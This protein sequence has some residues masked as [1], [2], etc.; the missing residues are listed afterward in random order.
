M[1]KV[2]EALQKKYNL[3]LMNSDIAQD[4]YGP[5]KKWLRFYLNFCK[6]YSH[7]YADAK[8]LLLFLEKLQKKKQTPSQQSQAKKA[9]ELYYSGI[10][11]TDSPSENSIPLDKIHEDIKRFE[12]KT[13]EDPWRIAV[14]SIKNEIELRHYSKKT[15]KAYTL[16]AE[17]FRYFT[18]DKLPESLTPEDVKDFLT[19]LAVKKKVSASSQNQA[20]NALLF[21]FRHVLKRDRKSVV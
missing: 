6:K 20:F 8:S 9:V 4:Q 19:F 14:N 18:K 5:C 10:E 13:I 17:K 15:L 3:L 12:S 21:F 1:I 7:A 16:W 11:K 2:P